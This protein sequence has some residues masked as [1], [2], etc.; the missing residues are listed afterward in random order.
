[1]KQFE[2][3]ILA[4]TKASSIQNISTIQQ[5]WAGYGSIVRITL[6]GGLYSAVVAK[7]IK[8]NSVGAHPRN[9]DTNFAHQRKVKSYEVEL[10]WYKH[11]AQ[12]SSKECIIPNC[13]G[14][15]EHADEKLL[16]LEDLDAKGFSARRTSLSVAEA[17]VVL[18]WL[19]NFH[20]L[21][22]QTKPE[23]LWERGTYWHLATRPDEFEK[24]SAS[25]LKMKAK[26]I[27]EALNSCQYQTIVHGDAKVA[28]FCFSQD[29]K[30]VAAVDFQ[31]V[32]GGCGMKDV[33]Y[34]LGSCLDEETCE[35]YEE[36]LLSHYFNT[37]K[38]GVK[39]SQPS[40]LPNDVEKE[41]R[42]LYAFAWSDFT[43]F[44]LGW[45]PTHAKL[46]GYSTLLMDKALKLI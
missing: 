30:R 28:N 1:M 5:L 41:Y 27:D 20:A 19:A 6:K 17:K 24:M 46:N 44:L 40:L 21:F 45:M 31:Y 22:M 37:L 32:G 39:Q 25:E 11:Y 23:G 8:S 2:K 36:E 35:Q 33:V 43:R 9:W 3:Q 10:Y 42:S 38:Q 16:I 29:M 15:L 12:Q 18:S 4:V 34:F 14:Y 7:H 13:L 26:A